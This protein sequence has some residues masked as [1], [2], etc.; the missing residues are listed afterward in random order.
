MESLGEGLYL[1]VRAAPI[2]LM[3]QDHKPNFLKA[4]IGQA[5]LI[6]P[7]PC[8]ILGEGGGEGR[9]QGINSVLTLQGHPIYGVVR[10]LGDFSAA[11]LLLR[12]VSSQN[13]LGCRWG[14]RK[15]GHNERETAKFLEAASKMTS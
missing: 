7:T 14:H 5:A 4:T 3:K 6:N 11:S 8:F 10:K 9:S 12:K 2:S 13:Y 15:P 1:G